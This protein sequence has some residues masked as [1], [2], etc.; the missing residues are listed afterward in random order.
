MIFTPGGRLR[1]RMGVTPQPM[2]STVTRAPLGLD[3]ITSCGLATATGSIGSAAR[4]TSPVRSAPI[5]AVVPVTEPAG[6][7]ATVSPAVGETAPAS[8]FGRLDISSQATLT[9]AITSPAAASA[10]GEGRGRLGTLS[11]AP[12]LALA[13]GC[14]AGSGWATGTGAGCS[15]AGGGG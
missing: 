5:S 9:P 7:P 12:A 1:I 14:G 13:G 6:A 10:R 4:N 11:A 15:I 3:V 8:S 2:P